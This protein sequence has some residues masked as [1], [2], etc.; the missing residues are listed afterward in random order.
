MAALRVMADENRCRKRYSARVMW[1][2]LS[3]SLDPLLLQSRRLLLEA[4]CCKVMDAMSVDDA[5]AR[6]SGQ[7]FDAVILCHTLKSDE[8]KAAYLRLRECVSISHFVCLQLFEDVSYDPW[9]FIH[10]VQ[11]TAS[12]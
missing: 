12:R 1:R 6:C 2:V 8:V 11:Q 7:H 9:T 3:I 4:S 10:R 5:I